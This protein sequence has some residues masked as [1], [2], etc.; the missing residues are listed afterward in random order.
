MG[1]LFYTLG[2][3]YNIDEFGQVSKQTM[4]GIDGSYNRIVKRILDVCCSLLALIFFSPI[5]L[6]LMTLVRINLGSPVLF[7]Q[8]RP[9]KDEKIFQLFKFR[10]MSDARDENG[11]LLDDTER[12]TKFGRF[13]R[14]T[15]L[16]ELP[17][18]INILKGEMSIVGP[19]PLAIEY[20][21]YYTAEEHHRHDVRP[22]LT[23]LAQVSGRNALSWEEKFQYD[24]QYINDLSFINDLRIIIRTFVKVIQHEGIGQAEEAPESLH[25]LRKDWIDVKGEIRAGSSKCQNEK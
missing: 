19:R 17:E 9:G 7:K 5:F 23:G 20:L 8:K 22:G 1:T 3:K 18:L 10:S 25:I 6:I 24:I 4:N 13:L 16:D 15:S 2:M 12:L 14:A 11:E 21:P